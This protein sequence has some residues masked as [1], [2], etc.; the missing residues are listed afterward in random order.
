MKTKNMNKLAWLDLSI[1][2]LCFVISIYYYFVNPNITLIYVN[3]C[4][5]FASIYIN[6]WNYFYT[7]N[8]A[9]KTK[10]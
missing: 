9:M 5:L 7:K 1:L 3:F 10:K 8:L 2:I 4:L 6:I